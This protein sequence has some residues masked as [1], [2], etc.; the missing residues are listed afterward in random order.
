MDTSTQLQIETLTGELWRLRGW[1]VTPAT[2]ELPRLKQLSQANSSLKDLAL[3]SHIGQ[4][5]EG[6]IDTMTAPF[7]EIE[8]KSVTAE[9]LQWAL[10][11]LLRRVRKNKSAR[12]READAVAHLG[13]D[14]SLSTFRKSE[15]LWTVLRLLAAHMVERACVSS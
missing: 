1:G 13:L 11:L 6:E 14:V 15:T 3:V 9:D 2:A 4:Y 7:Y 10:K 8:G 5:I 12:V